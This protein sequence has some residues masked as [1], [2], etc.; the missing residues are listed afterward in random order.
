LRAIDGEWGSFRESE[1]AQG[2]SRSFRELQGATEKFNELQGALGSFRDLVPDE[3][4]STD[5]RMN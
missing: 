2:A 3:V 4:A 1:E 5:E